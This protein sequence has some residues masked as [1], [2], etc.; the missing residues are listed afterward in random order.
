MDTGHDHGPHDP[1]TAD[2]ANWWIPESLGLA[3][4]AVALALYLLGVHRH[5]DRGQWPRWRTVAWITGL[6]CV[7]AGWAGPLAESARHD[8]TAHMATHLLVGMIGPLLLVLAAP[9]TLALR[10]LPASGARTV[11]AV[12][13]S[14]PVR[15]VTHPVGAAVLNGGGLW[16]LYATGLFEL[17]HRSMGL[18]VLI[19]VHVLLAGIAFTVAMI[20]PDPNPHR[21]SLRTRATVLVLFIAAHSVLGKWLYAYPPAGVDPA[22]ARVG[23]QLM[24]YGGDVVDLM[25][26]AL[27]FAGWYPGSRFRS[28]LLPGN[29]ALARREHR[30]RREQR[31][32]REHRV[33]PTGQPLESGHIDPGGT[34]WPPRSAGTS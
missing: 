15:L 24:Y 1:T 12:L 31:E 33:D 21:A 29:P 25:I 17:M 26:L 10:T 34:P 27:L 28:R 2:A 16:L 20:G 6:T 23:A 22:D 13:R 18:H 14:P 3:V 30:D 19:H 11:S 4:L 9:V 32:R 8:F 5:G 7:A